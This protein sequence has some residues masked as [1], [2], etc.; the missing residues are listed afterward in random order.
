MKTLSDFKRAMQLGSEWLRKHVNEID[1]FSRT[2]IKVCKDHVYLKD[3]ISGKEARLDFP[4]ASEFKINEN[5]EA[6]IYWPESYT[7]EGI[8]KV[9][10]PKKLVLTYRKAE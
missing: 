3:S 2:V 7:Y 5:G 6:E 1:F 8:E 4:K 10:I 9:I